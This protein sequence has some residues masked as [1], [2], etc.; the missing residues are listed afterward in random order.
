MPTMILTRDNGTITEIALPQD[1]KSQDFGT[2]L[3][4]YDSD[5]RLIYYTNL[6]NVVELVV[7]F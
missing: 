6:D 7:Q 5:D 1:Y 3:Y 4:L 2:D